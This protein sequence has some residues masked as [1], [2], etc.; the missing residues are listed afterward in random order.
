MNI[1][2]LK[3][4]SRGI[5]LVLFSIS[6]Q[7]LAQ[8][9]P[10]KLNFRPT[11]EWKNNLFAKTSKPGFRQY[12]VFQFQ[13]PLSAQ[14]IQNLKKS[15]W[16]PGF[17]LTGS[18]YIMGVP[19]QTTEAGLIASGVIA[20]STIKPEQKCDPVLFL[21]LENEIDSSDRVVEFLPHKGVEITQL[22]KIWQQGRW[23]KLLEVWPG[24]V[25][26]WKVEATPL[27]IRHLLEENWLFYLEESQGQ[28]QPF[29]QISGQNSRTSFIQSGLAG[30]SGKGISIGIGDG[31]MVETHADLESNQ[32]NLTSNKV[33]SFTDH[34]DH[35]TG[36]I[37]GKGLL[38]ADKKGMAPEA[39]TY[40]LQTSG[41]LSLI[42]NLKTN[43]G[44]RLTNNS[45]GVN[46]NCA[47]AGN[48]NVTSV[49]LDNQAQDNP[50]IL[51]VF[52][53]GNQGGSTCGGYPTGFFNLA[54][55]YPIAKNC[56][57]VGAVNTDDGLTW[58][59]SKGPTRDGR[60]KPEI[61]AQGNETFSTVP[62]DLYAEKSGTSMAA[63]VVTG[64][65]ALLVERYKA[66][67]NNQY[68]E[69]AL[70]KALICNTADDV[71]NPQVDFASGFGRLNARRAKK[72]LDQ[73]FYSS[74]QVVS[75]GLKTIQ[76]TAPAQ[77]SQLK[78]ML[79][80]TDPAGLANGSANLV[81]D[82]DLK[83]SKSGGQVFLPW[84]LDASPSGANQNAIRAEDHVNNMEQV[85]LPVTAGEAVQVKV[86]CGNLAEG[87]QKYW[88][89]YE[90]LSPELVLTAPESQSWKEAGA[91]TDFRWD[92]S[93]I[94]FSQLAIES[95]LDSISGWTHFQ[96]CGAPPSGLSTFS[97]PQTGLQKRF[98][99][100]KGTGH[101]GIT[102]SNV[103]G[104]WLSPKAI[105]QTET[106]AQN[107]R[108]SW[109]AIPDASTYEILRLDFNEG[110]WKH[111]AWQTQTQHFV[112]G[113]ETGERF[114]FSVKPW[115]SGKPGMISDGKMVVPP[116]T[117]I[118]PWGLDVGLTGIVAPQNARAFS[119]QMANQ[120]P[121][122]FKAKNYGN[123]AI[124]GKSTSFFFR[125][126][127][128]PVQAFTVLLY[129][130]PGQE[131]EWEVPSVSI[132]AALG[133]YSLTA[134]FSNSEDVNLAN[135]TLCWKFRQVENPA[136]VLPKT[137][138]FQNAENETLSHT[139]FALSQ[140]PEGDVHLENGAQLSSQNPLLPTTF[141]QKAMV[142]SKDKIDGK[143]GKAELILTYNLSQYTETQQ[144]ALDFDWLP[145]GAMTEGN[146]LSIR[147]N[148][149]GD[150]IDVLRFWQINYTPKELK[151]FRGIDLISLLQ[152]QKPSA[153]FQIRFE[154]SGQRPA[155][156][157]NGQGYAFDNL[158]LSIPSKDV[159]ITKLLAPSGG[160]DIPNQQKQVK[161]RLFNTSDQP[162]QNIRLG[163]SLNGQIPVEEIL[164]VLASQDSL[165]FQF[166]EFLPAGIVGL[167]TFKFWVK[168]QDDTYPANDT[169]RNL[170]VF[171]S[172]KVLAYP[173]Y[174]DFENG[175][176][177]WHAYGSNNSWEWGKPSKN[178]QVIDTAGNGL[179]I[180][181]T[182]LDGNY[183]GNT[184]A[185]LESP[186]FD[187]S[188]SESQFQFSF[189]G[190]IQT[191]NE[192][193]YLWLE[194]SEDGQNWQ[195]IGRQNSG[196]NW[197][198][199][200]S[201]QWCGDLSGWKVHSHPVDLIPFQNKS[202]MRFRFGFSS[203]V[204]LHFEGAGLDDIHLEPKIKILKDSS[205]SQ[206][207][208][209]GQMRA[210]MSFE[211]QNGMVAEVENLSELGTVAL[212]MVNKPGAIRFQDYTPYLS[213][214]Y[215]ISPE[216][217][218]LDLVKVR[219]YIAE[220]DLLA[221][222]GADSS[223]KSFQN[224][225]VYKYS[226]PNED[227]LLDNNKFELGQST[228]IQPFKILKVPTAGGYFLEFSVAS[229]SEFYISGHDL[230]PSDDPLPVKLIYFTGRSSGAKNEIKLEWKTASEVNADRFEIGISCDGKNF[231][232]IH[233]EKAKGGLSAGA[234]YQFNH[235]LN[236][237]C[238]NE[239][240]I[241]RLRQFD[242]E[243]EK[244]VSENFAQ[245]KN[246]MQG[247]SLI[248][249]ENPV[250][251][252][253]E[254]RG[255]ENEARLMLSNLEGKVIFETN[256]ENENLSKDISGIPAGM[257]QLKIFQNNQWQHFRLLKK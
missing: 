97:L 47:K 157:V 111:M 191:E 198:N 134:W 62:F 242:F 228:F 32:T 190:N 64:S 28:D 83:V 128:G 146:G 176:G 35:V 202:Q 223:V 73:G 158:T 108:L 179:K 243:N 45:Y 44:I 36:T 40:N 233:N 171:I 144:L 121:V 192:Y 152:G 165:D 139:Q 244:P 114:A 209:Q 155:E 178:M 69:S 118:C 167:Q 207:S 219:L 67:N 115:F 82:L 6:M 232:T 181:A 89:V 129:L 10:Q 90:W 249:V 173:Y 76:L 252:Q 215:L 99:R 15:G 183:K 216:F 50:D 33:A 220:E 213:R 141:G 16:M 112:S 11:S 135:D 19:A 166:L 150:W 170:S 105:L 2:L 58:F 80:W 25:Q 217:Q 199:H 208:S 51:H 65:I 225:G 116:S 107:A 26:K 104:I 39:K 52:A 210:W 200:A 100:L 71:G 21:N 72:V 119:Q 211:N 8:I 248:R 12:W 133:N 229:F 13:N 247:R 206:N 85:S 159:V 212:K 3:W 1:T 43:Y 125:L 186:C 86:S 48:Y 46:L 84:V 205:F 197:Y 201:H 161:I 96:N 234:L 70:L 38:Q 18:A 164:P 93:Q 246:P 163:Y 98:F 81:H 257:Y 4:L 251:N 37:S 74:D 57:T 41:V 193:D 168:A 235:I 63:P 148:E 174:E 253:L 182:R 156:L 195:K 55:G 184:Q 143:T 245:V 136:M 151:E 162:A 123:Q 137:N 68:P 79:C 147:A 142:L 60:V 145:F 254:I 154:F 94:S 91:A 187:L 256:A 122:K 113:L 132:P 17:G 95:S 31:G 117:G 53:A 227:L 49:F 56:L 194:V 109:N 30:L 189:N 218:P 236:G 131:K 66:L 75:N 102:Y 180:W 59:S 238:S 239:N 226:G 78:I 61:V 241:F 185:Y 20:F 24:Q 120:N 237:F 110:T 88:L 204:S 138:N 127:Q 14:Q 7:A 153:I 77:S 5:L 255:L 250:L 196:T 160:C 221:L 106:C 231:E 140:L 124:S 130:E 126:N 29:H 9:S 92:V 224:L 175:A 222:Q 240:L 22:K 230:S 203:D 87:I 169:T 42:Q 103:V 149:T 214:N 23:G 188:G 101:Q 177:F 27:Q 172:P 34:Q 54:E